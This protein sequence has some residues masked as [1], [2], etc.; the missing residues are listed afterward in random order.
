M[1]SQ[2]SELFVCFFLASILMLL[3]SLNGV[4][5]DRAHRWNIPVLNH[6]WLEDCFS[7]WSNLPASGHGQAQK[8]STFPPGTNFMRILAQKSLAGL[9]LPENQTPIP[10]SEPTVKSSAAAPITRPVSAT[11][12]IPTHPDEGAKV[13]VSAAQDN[14]EIDEAIVATGHPPDEMDVDPGVPAVDVSRSNKP[15]SGPITRPTRQIASPKIS[16][17]TKKSTSTT[18]PTTHDSIEI[19]NEPMSTTANRPVSRKVPRKQPT[20]NQDEVA[21]L[22]GP[23]KVK[24][25]RSNPKPATSAPLSRTTSEK[26]PRKT[27]STVNERAGNGQSSKTAS[28]SPLKRNATHPQGA[29]VPVRANVVSSDD[30]DDEMPRLRSPVLPLPKSKKPTS[31]PVPARPPPDDEPEETS[32]SPDPLPIR[33][34]RKAA[35][36]AAANL[37]G[38]MQDVRAYEQDLKTSQ[39]DVRK[40][41]MSGASTKEPSKKRPFN[42][43]DD[44]EDEVVPPPSKGKGKQWGNDSDEEMSSSH[45][46]PSKKPVPKAV[47]RAKT[48][49]DAR[50]VIKVV[51]CST[52]N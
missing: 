8:Y 33:S 29:K 12:S 19:D 30:D 38:V 41:R 28:Q 2:P 23:S 9:D 43:E 40:M 13:R 6:T 37:K 22:P 14:M 36:T 10:L 7:T 26:S 52:P 5:V 24:S 50:Y 49:N 42:T 46:G 15:K 32:L 18:L 34:R 39:G 20:R 17:T 1:S 25:T 35:T 11:A 47:K 4:K 31:K 27:V 45:P 21:P 51:F 48:G 3:C 16:P 44:E